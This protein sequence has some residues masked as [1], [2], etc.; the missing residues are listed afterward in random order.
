MKLLDP[1]SVTILPPVPDSSKIVVTPVNYT[2]ARSR[3]TS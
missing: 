3:P 1:G 2:E